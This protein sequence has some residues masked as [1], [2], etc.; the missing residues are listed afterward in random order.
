MQTSKKPLIVFEGI[1]GA[2]KT[3]QI[4]RLHQWLLQQRIPTVVFRE[5]GGTDVGERIRD[6]IKSCTTSKLTQLF[7]FNAARSVLLD[8]IR[9][10][11]ETHWVLLDRYVYSTWVYQGGGDVPSQTIQACQDALDIIEPDLVFLFLHQKR[12]DP[13]D[14]IER[15]APHPD[16]LKERYLALIKSPTWIIL[17]DQSIDELFDLI[18]SMIQRAT[19]VD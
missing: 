10:L 15:T 5:P 16:I 13:S 9:R 2:G 18:V 8:E 11:Q 1:D 17:P 7:L 14:E 6:I 4:E 12:S 3:T 19:T